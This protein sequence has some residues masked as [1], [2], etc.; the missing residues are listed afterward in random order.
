MNRNHLRGLFL[1]IVLCGMASLG[2]AQSAPAASLAAAQLAA[3][4]S[5]VQQFQALINRDLQTTLDHPFGMLQDPKGIYLPNFGVVFHMEMNLAPMRMVS[6]FDVR[7][8]TEEELQQSHGT[9]LQRIR[10]LKA[11]LSELLR[12]HGAELSA[13]PPEQNVAVAVHLFNM[14]SERTEGLP[15]QIVIEVSRGMLADPQARIGSAEE[16]RKKVTFFDF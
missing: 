2:W 14:P 13:V 6:M 16:F 10:E 1:G 9:K 11:H 3:L 4:R 7:P 15:T 8:Y 12:L 5:Q